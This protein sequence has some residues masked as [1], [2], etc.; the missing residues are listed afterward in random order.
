[1]RTTF[2]IIASL[3]RRIESA[4]TGAMSVRSNPITKQIWT[5][6]ASLRILTC[7]TMNGRFA[8]H[9]CNSLRRNSCLT[10]KAGAEPQSI[11]SSPMVRLSLVGLVSGSVIFNNVF[12]HS[13]CDIKDSI[14]MQGCEHWPQRQAEPYVICDKYVTIEDG[15]V[16]GEDLEYDRKRFQVSPSGIVVI[17]K[18]C[19]VKSDG[20]VVAGGFTP[21]PGSIRPRSIAAGSVRITPEVGQE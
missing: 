15:A 10:M 1:M 20:T 19:I 4:D 13:Y 6:A 3:V 14:L 21:P 5:C 11:A 16:I 8:R 18:G 7:T 9:R 12:V 17:P 2:W